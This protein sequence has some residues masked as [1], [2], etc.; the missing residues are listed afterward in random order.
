M[1]GTLIK[2]AGAV[3]FGYL[4]WCAIRPRYALE[5]VVGKQGVKSHKR[6]PIAHQASVIE[7]FEK[8]PSF[9]SDVT[10]CATRRSDG[11]LRLVCKGRVDPG[12]RQRIRNFLMTVM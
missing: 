9:D 11:H 3:L 4:V 2:L 6:L 8:L 10:I 7:F 1:F 12:T 5:V